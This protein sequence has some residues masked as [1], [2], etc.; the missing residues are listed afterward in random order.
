MVTWV[1]AA[2]PITGD[3]NST[4]W[5][6]YTIRQVIASGQISNTGE[7]YVRVTFESSS[8]QALTISKAYI[9]HAAAA[10]DAY[11]FESAPTELKFNTGLSGFAIS[12]ATQ[13]VS[14]Q[15]TFSI[16]ASKNLIVSFYVSGDATR[17]DIR[18][19]VTQTGW[20]AYYRLLAND[21]ATVNASAYSTGAAVLGVMRV[22]AGSED[23]TGQVIWFS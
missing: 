20:T 13:I 14:D 4:D 11:D 5:S 21:E 2:G 17:D 23:S 15:T 19:K 22:E 6:G 10:G 1:N 3:G 18:Q 9:G 12:S 16:Q 8:A 7:T